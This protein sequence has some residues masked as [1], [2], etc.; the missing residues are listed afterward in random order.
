MLISGKNKFVESQFTSEDELKKMVVE[1]HAEGLNLKFIPSF[2]QDRPSHDI[3][4][5]Y[6]I[7]TRFIQSLLWSLSHLK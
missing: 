4:I 7:F 2:H 6:Y 5:F 1:H 3:V